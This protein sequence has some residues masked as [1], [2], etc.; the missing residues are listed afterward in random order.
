MSRESEFGEMLRGMRVAG[1]L[2]QEE[3]ADRACLSA[4]AIASLERGRRRYP[5]AST[6]A[7][8]ALALGLSPDEQAAL[9]QADRLDPRALARA[10]L[11]PGPGRRRHPGGPA[12]VRGYRGRQ[13][14]RQAKMLAGPVKSGG[15]RRQDLPR[16]SPRRRHPGAPA[17]CRRAR[18]AAAGPPAGR[19]QAQRDQPLH[20]AARTGG[21]GRRRGDLRCAPYGAGEPGLAG[22]QEERAGATTPPPPKPSTSTASVNPVNSQCRCRQAPGTQGLQ[23]AAVIRRGR[24]RGSLAGPPVN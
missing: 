21:S 9:T 22:Q 24:S 14:A 4:D 8:L 6:V 15:R 1:G 20:R 23:P 11:G 2:S 18:R 5:R 17:R 10:L 19:C 3:L 16:S 13:A 7:A 12:S